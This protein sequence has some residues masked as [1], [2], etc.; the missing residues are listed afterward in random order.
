MRAEYLVTPV[1]FAL[2]PRLRYP[3]INGAE[4]VQ[5]LLRIGSRTTASRPKYR[6][7]VRLI[8]SGG[9]VDAADL[10]QLGLEERIE[11]SADPESPMRQLLAE[12]PGRAAIAVKDED[13]VQR[14]QQGADDRAAAP[15]HRMTNQLKRLLADHTLLEG[16]APDCHYDVL[17]RDYD[18]DGNDL[19]IEVKA[20]ATP[21][22]C[23]WRSAKS[24][25]TGIA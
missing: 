7:L 4:R 2:D 16:R 9:V 11:L 10:D 3:I 25:R 13:D 1:V 20:R 18:R 12:Q 14:L 17:V 23:A 6:A 15:A 19:M 22:R 24:S 8:G 5:V 21:R